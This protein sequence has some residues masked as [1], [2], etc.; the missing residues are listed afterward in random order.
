LSLPNGQR[1]GAAGRDPRRALPPLPVNGFS[2]SSQPG[3]FKAL[4]LLTDLR[5][6]ASLAAGGVEL[7]PCR[8][9]ER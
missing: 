6:T 3:C 7:R 9:R 2:E 4:A 5:E 8:S 1:A